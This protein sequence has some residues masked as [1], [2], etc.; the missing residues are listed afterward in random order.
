MGASTTYPL[1]VT[2]TVPKF[3]ASPDDPGVRSVAPAG[4]D[5]NPATMTRTPKIA[6]RIAS[7]QTRGTGQAYLRRSV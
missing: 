6:A 2:P 3:S 5:A 7:T 1:P 4:T